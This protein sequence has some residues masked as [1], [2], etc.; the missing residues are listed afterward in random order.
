MLTTLV[1][2]LRDQLL[3]AKGLQTLGELADDMH[4]TRQTMARFLRGG[5]VSF[6]TLEAIETWLAT[7]KPP[8]E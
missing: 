7:R 6:S 8:Y 5:T 4:L 1:N 3:R 2:D